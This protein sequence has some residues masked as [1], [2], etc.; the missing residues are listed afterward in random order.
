MLLSLNQLVCTREEQPLF[1]SLTVQFTAGTCVELLGA[2]GA[3]KTT[4]LRTLAGLYSQYEGTFECADFLFQGHPMGLD[5]LMTPLENLAWFAGLEGQRLSDERAAELLG[6]VGM[7]SL[8]MTP[9]QQLSQ[10]QQR[11]VTM[12]RW[13][14]SNAQLWLLDEPYTSLDKEGQVLLN[15]LLS[16]H[17]DEGGTVLAATHLPLQVS[18]KTELVLHPVRVPV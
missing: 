9:C 3:G 13:L 17:C 6:E 11:R 15:R 14:L 16:R 18:N 8:A 7:I 2:N 10:G 12:A 1:E 5:E 4:L